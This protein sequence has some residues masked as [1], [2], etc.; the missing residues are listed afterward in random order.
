MKKLFGLIL[1]LFVSVNSF[2][3]TDS[4]QMYRWEEVLSAEPDTVFGISLSKMKL[5]SL[6]DELKKFRNLV[7]LDAGKNKLK[8]LPEFVAEFHALKVLNLEKNNLDILPIEICRMQGLERLI[9]NR[10]N[11]EKLPDCFGY[12]EQLKYIDLYDNPIRTLPESLTQLS[13][14]DEIDLSGIKFSPTF[15]NSWKSKLP[16]VKFVFDAPCDCME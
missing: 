4:I 15:Q 3:Q 10:N 9:L 14:L 13:N 2:C 1:M 5:D 11:I 8:E 7:I 6:P 16:N 12:V